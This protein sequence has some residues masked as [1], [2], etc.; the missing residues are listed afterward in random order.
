[1]L[2]HDWDDEGGDPPTTQAIHA[3]QALVQTA[4]AHF[5]GVASERLQPFAI[6]PTPDG[7]VTVEW[8]CEDR[9]LSV[10]VNPRGRLD[11][12]TAAGM[13]AARVYA[14]DADISPER[15][16]A[17]LASVLRAAEA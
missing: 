10:D 17:L 6:E 12:V 13:G 5:P 9:L 15:I 3:A 14:E 16:H 7:G 1:M 2:E 4:C 8:R 11:Y